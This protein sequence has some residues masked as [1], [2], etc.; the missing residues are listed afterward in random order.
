MYDVLLVDDEVNILEGIAKMVDWSGCD[1]R[2]QG[3]ASNGLIA[4]EM[5]KKSPPDIVIT[6]IKM[7]GM[8]GVE[9]IEKVYYLLPETQFIVLSGYNEFEYAKTA[10]RYGAKHYL[11]K[12]SNENK[13]QEA[14]SQVVQELTER[15]EKDLFLEEMNL[16]LEKVIPKAKEQLLRE[17]ITNK[18]YGLKEWEYYQELFRLPPTSQQFRLTVF[19]LDDS[20]EYEHLFALREIITKELENRQ[21]I[22]LSTILLD[23]VVLLTEGVG[24]EELFEKVKALKETY[25]NFYSA[26]FTTAISSLGTIADLRMLYH[27]T[28]DCLNQKFYIGNGGIIT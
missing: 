15:K 1:T 26:T 20:H 5:I 14:L 3:K 4:F 17:F 23:R 10:M 16:S 21:V 8:S 7:P 6:D 9:L 22:L 2:L 25:K 24:R 27:E 18:K 28:L 19:A 13:I 11:L 12:P